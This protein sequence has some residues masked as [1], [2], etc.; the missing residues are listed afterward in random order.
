MNLKYFT[1][2]EFSSPDLPNSGIN[3][4]ST[5]LDLLDTLREHYGKPLRI[6]SGYRTKEHNEAVG[7]VPN[8][9]HL[10]G[11]AV[12]IA[13]TSSGERHD[14]LKLAMDI[15]FNRIGI[16][17]SFIHLDNDPAKPAGLVWTY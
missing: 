4:D 10:R 17:K 11:Y 2:D 3:M 6:T 15:G 8:S 13:A 5:L 9:S 12:D 14:I 7:G 16:A 1:L